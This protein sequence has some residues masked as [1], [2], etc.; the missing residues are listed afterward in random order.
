MLEVKG[1]KENPFHLSFGMVIIEDKK[2]AMIHKEGGDYTLPRETVKLKESL[3]E[4]LKRGAH[5]EVGLLVDVKKYLGSLK[6][7]FFRDGE[8]VEKTTCYFLL[9]KNGKIKKTPRSYEKH[10]SVLWLSLPD[11]IGLLYQE[12]NS[13]WE[14]LD[15]FLS[16]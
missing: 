2:V 11:A 15:R 9:K 16:L 6:I 13:E 4:A 10:D 5:E 1:T 8:K 14:M 7:F 12:K 3:E